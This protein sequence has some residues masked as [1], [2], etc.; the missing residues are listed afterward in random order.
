M[1]VKAATKIKNS[2]TKWWLTPLITFIAVLLFSLTAFTT[3]LIMAKVTK[4][5]SPIA[6]LVEAQVILSND[7]DVLAA[8]ASGTL[9]SKHQSWLVFIPRE[10][11]VAAAV[12]PVLVG[13]DTKA[14]ATTGS[15]NA[16]GQV[17]YGRGTPNNKIGMYVQNTADDI[18]ASA[19]LI[20]SNGG[21][22]GYVL[23]TMNLS[24]RGSGSW[25][26][27]FDAA[28][29][30]H[31]IPLIQLFNAGSCNPDEMDF[32]GLAEMLNGLTWPTEHRYISIFNEVNAGDYWCG[33][34]SP[35]AYAQTL[36]KAITA[37]KDKS[38]NFFIMPAAFN[39]SAR[40]G[41]VS[42]EGAKY[43]GEDAFLSGMN[44]AVPGIFGRIDGWATHAYPQP[45]FSG[46]I[47]GGRDSILNYKWELS[48]VSSFGAGSLPVFITETG[49]LHKEGQESCGQYSQS[50]LLSSSSVSARYKEAYVNYWLPDSRVVA[51]TPFI[52]RSNDPCAAGFA[53]QK[54]D[55][56]WYPQ[57]EM[58]LAIPKT[59]GIPS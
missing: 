48:L 47:A 31:V 18:S 55:G 30:N 44:Q 26:S 49:W 20:N 39:S 58:L 7:E 12:V 15:S 4:Q 28:T 45:N 1:I 10:T 33:N 14:V 57:A 29:S 50:G 3:P 43:I 51:I 21:D 46:V 40:S 32:E 19:D 8:S 59:S 38:Q 54:P 24:D 41:A 16:S 23:L 13:S 22:W 56:S 2:E 5:H 35:E 53:W 52:F 9:D 36:D 11:E 42:N 37:F 27:L 6:S 25:Q 17:F 34:A